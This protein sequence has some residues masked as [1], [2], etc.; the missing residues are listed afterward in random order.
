MDTK[1]L[2]MTNEEIIEYAHK[3]NVTLPSKIDESNRD[4]VIINIQ[5]K[6]LEKDSFDLEVELP[7]IREEKLKEM[8]KNIKTKVET[9][10]F[11]SLTK[12]AVDKLENS[13][14]RRAMK[15]VRV[16]ISCND[17]NKRNFKGEIFTV[18]N[19]KIPYIKKFVPFN[20]PTHIPQIMYDML[21]E[22]LLQ[23]F[24]EEKSPTGR[25]VKKS[26]LIPEYNIEVLP[27]LTAKELNAI[28]QKQLAENSN[29]EE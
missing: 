6:A 22:R 15:L 24:Y 9:L 29:I 11:A 5:K 16:R 13:V 8:E 21:K 2:E 10:T 27:P 3:Y 1:K 17:T 28:R 20:S 4:S 12:K 23:I 18:Q 14:F 19:S 25:K 26:R 7:K